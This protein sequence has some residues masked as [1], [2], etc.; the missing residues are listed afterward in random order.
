MMDGMSIRPLATESLGVRSTCVYI[1]T[2]DVR[3]LVD[4]GVSLGPRFR[5]I[6]HPREYQRLEKCRRKIAQYANDA[7]IV[8]ISHYHYDHCTPT[9]TDYV[10]NYSDREV[11]R[12]IYQKKV[13][14]LRIIE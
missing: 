2:P 4:P 14:W 10:W 9:Y 11:A 8:T 13:V 6:P 1:Q 12:N 3:V 5:L 7:E